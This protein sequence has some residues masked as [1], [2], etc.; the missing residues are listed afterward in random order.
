ML[1]FLI[2]TAFATD[3]IPREDLF[4]N[5]DRAAARV[6]PD[7]QT[8]AF[9]APVDGVLNIWTAPWDAPAEATALTDDDGRGIRNIRWSEDSAYVLY[10]QD[11]DGDENWHVYA[12]PAEGG[13]ARDLTPYGDVAASIQQTS[14]ADPT[15]VMISINDRKARLHDLYLV[16]IETGSRVRIE[17]NKGYLGYVT[18]DD[19]NVRLASKFKLDGGME[20]FQKN[21]KGKWESFFTVGMEDSLTTSAV[22]FGKDGTLYMIDSR[23]RKTA[24]LVAVDMDTGASKIVFEDERADV[25]DVMVHPETW[26]IQAVAS[27]YERTEWTVLDKDLAGDLDF[28]RTVTDGELQVTSRSRDDQHWT[29]AYV[30]DDGPVQYW[31]YDREAGRVKF[32]FTNRSALDGVDLAP[33]YAR[34]LP[35]RDGLELV[36]YLTLPVGTDPDGDGVPDTALPTVLLVHGGPW[37][38]DHWGYNPYHQWLANRGYAVLSVNFRGSTGF[39]KDHLNAG[40]RE[41]AGKMHDDLIDA[42]NWAVDEG[43]AD[44][45]KVAIMG[46]SYGGYATLVG[47]TFTPDVF[48]CGVDIVGPSNIVTL[49]ETIPPY[50]KPAIELFAKRVGDHRTKEGKAFLESRSPLTYVDAI[51]KPLLIAQGANDPRVK[52]SEAD[53][54]VE[55]MQSREI[56]VTYALFPDEGHGFRRPENSLAFTAVSEAFLAEHL[57]GAVEPVGDDF[58]GSTITVPTGAELVPGVGE[59]LPP[60]AAPSE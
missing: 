30:D 34:V 33:M 6:S 11:V 49:L 57:G 10:G 5:P 60:P 44:K 43:V 3:L 4:G 22:A 20:T 51:E 38:R 17:K 36:S 48:A 55:A 32:L 1:T 42:V 31:A 58:E 26:E 24:A 9:L 23:D 27:N 39:G 8:L 12:I 41:W 52:Q 18:D 2:S 19:F 47:L 16:D 29:L 46:G 35:A 14:E 37:A 25:S 40:N 45:D 56:P 28:L 15:H 54:I 53:Q 50:W 13:K 7:G 21:D 59:V